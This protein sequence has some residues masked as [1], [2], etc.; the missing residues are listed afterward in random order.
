MA[1]TYFKGPELRKHVDAQQ[2]YIHDF[3]VEGPARDLFENY[4]AIAPEKV[5]EHV[6]EVRDRAFNNMPYACIGSLRFLNL[7]LSQHPQYQ[8]VLARLS[9]HQSLLDLG[10]CFA[11]DIRKLVHDGAPS[12]QLYGIDIDPAFLELG[13]DLFLD[14][15][16]LNSTFIVADLFSAPTPDLLKSL[17]GGV[18][19]V[20]AASFFNLFDW[21][22]QRVLAKH[23]ISLMKP[24]QGSVILGRQLGSSEPGEYPHLK[25]DGTTTYWHDIVSWQRLWDEVGQ[26]TGTSWRVNASLDEKEFAY[27]D[28]AWGIPSQRRLV[29]AVFKR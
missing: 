13:Y 25:K 24:K 15:D 3:Q 29:F 20:Y 7:S 19:M 22:Q 5:I 27:R 23:V 6:S 12:S 11:Q 26:E 28:N 16:K 4:S 2:W 17:D 1:A 18:D 9:D 10:C 21:K 8:N 14:R